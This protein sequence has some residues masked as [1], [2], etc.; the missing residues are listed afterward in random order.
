MSGFVG[1][2]LK[3][4]GFVLLMVS[5]V[6]L[7]GRVVRLSWDHSTPLRDLVDN[8]RLLV[9]DPLAARSI[10]P[11]TEL[12]KTA[13]YHS[14]DLQ[15][16]SDELVNLLRDPAN[17]PLTDSSLDLMRRLVTVARQQRSELREVNVALA[18]L[19]A[20]PPDPGVFKLAR[21]GAALGWSRSSALST[22]MGGS[23]ELLEGLGDL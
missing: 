3:L 2:L 17:R 10:R 13:R 19:L 11:M 12:V 8:L 16:L 18:S 22:L 4:I 23:S 15:L 14:A 1:Q 21:R 9:D 6:R 7:L 5:L 20:Q